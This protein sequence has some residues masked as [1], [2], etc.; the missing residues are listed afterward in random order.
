MCS[1]RLSCRHG[2]QLTDCDVFAVYCSEDREVVSS[3]SMRQV[4][5][6]GKPTHVR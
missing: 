4:E 3:T 5:L 1:C 2:Q 6:Q